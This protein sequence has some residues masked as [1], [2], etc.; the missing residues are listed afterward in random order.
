MTILQRYLVFFCFISHF[1][2]FSQDIELYQQFNGRYNFVTIGNTLNITENGLNTP[3]SIATSSD[4][5]LTLSEGTTIE[6]AYLYWAGSGTGDFTISLND[7]EITA[8]RTF[9]D[10]L[11][12]DRVFFAAFANVTTLV[13]TTGNGTYTLSE[14][15]LTDVIDTYC[16]S[17]TNFGGWAIVCITKNENFPL[18]QVNVYDGLQ[19]VP[20]YISMLLNNLNVYDNAGAGIGFLAWEGDAGISVNE[21]LTINNIEVENLP[22]N[23][24]NNAF[25]G[26]NWFTNSSDLYN[27]DI[28]FYDLES[29]IAIGDTEVTIELSSGQDFVMVNNI[30]TV[31]ASILPDA[32]VDIDNFVINCDSRFIQF[33]FTVSNTNGTAELPENTA[34]NIYANTTLLT[35]IYTDAVIE[36]GGFAMYTA[37]VD[38]PENIPDTFNLTIYV[39]ETN[40]ITE[41]D[42]TNNINT[43]EIT[44]VS[45]PEIIQL[46]N[47]EA[48]DLGYN[49][50]Y[51]DLNTFTSYFENTYATFTGF[52]ETE[53]DALANSNAISN[54]ANYTNNQQPQTIYYRYENE[55]CYTISTLEV[56]AVNCPPTIPQGFSPNNDGI[57]DTFNIQDLWTIFDRFELSIFNRYGTVIYKGNQ[58]TAP[59]D[60]TANTG[61]FKGNTL[62]TGTYYY[63]LKLQDELF[64]TYTGWVYLNK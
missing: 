14:L 15:D 11:D 19:H 53:T 33:D 42:E 7:T 16:P 46:P 9:T 62:P 26:T 1:I 17:G 4:A 44:F 6:A 38:I 52:Y 39:D 3:C 34:V 5:I 58:Q 51:F 8:E 43:T 30:V 28:D 37:L 63:V 64:T 36:T 32:T 45:A 47:L 23:P 60:G 29:Y 22:L 24:V 56:K 50:A 57:N 21:T 40:A 35:T 12:A 54:T 31:L 59:W 41:I 25:N 20:S 48:C 55:Y 61:N 49:T 10:A 18:H 13:Q 27:M 2:T